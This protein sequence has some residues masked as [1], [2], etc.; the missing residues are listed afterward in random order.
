MIGDGQERGRGS[1]CKRGKRNDFRISAAGAGVPQL[2]RGARSVGMRT[3]EPYT[4]VVGGFAKFPPRA[5][6]S[7]NENFFSLG[8]SARRKSVEDMFGM[9]ICPLKHC[10]NDCVVGLR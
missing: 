8:T 4:V 1:L 3:A 5:Q 10:G 7:R 6:F 2:P 9:L